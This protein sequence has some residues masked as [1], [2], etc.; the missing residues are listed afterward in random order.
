MK[1]ETWGQITN[2]R[3]DYEAEVWSISPLPSEGREVNAPNV[4]FVI[5]ILAV[6]IRPFSTLLIPNFCTEK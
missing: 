2:V 1:Y 6:V 3:T 4:S 5:L